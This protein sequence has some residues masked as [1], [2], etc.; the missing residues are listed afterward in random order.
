MKR[1]SQMAAGVVLF[2]DSEDGRRYLL[3]RSALTR[4]PI[5]E[6]PKGGVEAGETDEQAAVRELWEEAGIGETRITLFDGFREEERYVFT[7]G[8]GESRTLIVK[9]VIY[10]LA[11]TDEERVTISREAEEYRW[12]TYDE[13]M[14]LL[15]FPGKRFV[16]EAA[17]VLLCA[18]GRGRPERPA[19]FARPDAPAAP[20]ESARAV[21]PISVPGT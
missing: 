12:A 7:Q 13:A 11:K 17:E 8:K 14:R 21:I 19:G 15:R 20:A 10:F 9:R 6:F 1:V 4:R 18:D 16:L 2:R 5:W 3:M